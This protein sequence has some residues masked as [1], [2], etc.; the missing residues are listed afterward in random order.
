MIAKMS[1]SG[2]LATLAMVAAIYFG[3][4]VLI[5]ILLAYFLF[6]LL[7]PLAGWGERRRISRKVSAPIAILVFVGITGLVGWGGYG[8]FATLTQQL[9]Q[10]SQKIRGLV[11]SF[12]SK[13]NTIQKGTSTF[14]PKSPTNE[15]I[16]KV[17]VVK[18]AGGEGW[19]GFLLHGLNSVFAAVTTALLVPILTLFFLLEKSYLGKRLGAALEPGVSLESIKHDITQMVRGF[20]LG[21]LVVGTITAVGFLILFSVL[22]LEN[23]V[24]LAIFSGFINLIPIIGAVLGGLLPAIQAIL[25]FDTAGPVLIIMGSPVLLHFFVANVIM[26]KV[27]GSRINVNASAATIGLIFWGWSWGGLGLL[28]AIPLMALVRSFLSVKPATRAWADLIAESPSG[29]VTRLS[30]SLQSKKMKRAS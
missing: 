11:S 17:E 9:P 25:Q 28:L 3:S 6:I 7:D 29:P 15:D 14:L 13:A 22:H 4:T 23:P 19:T 8:T 10:Y 18:Q 27:V 12:Q 21:N 30:L 16:Q 1:G 26:P 2:V 5:P 20:F 24:A